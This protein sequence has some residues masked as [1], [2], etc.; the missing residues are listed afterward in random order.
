MTT[1]EDDYGEPDTKQHAPPVIG[2][3][4]AGPLYRRPAPYNHHS[5]GGHPRARLN[6][7]KVQF[8]NGTLTSLGRRIVEACPLP[9]STGIDEQELIKKLNG[10]NAYA[11][12]QRN[13]GEL[14]EASYL[15]Q[16]PSTGNY[17]R[18]N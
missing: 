2:Y 17:N 14:V 9:G 6:E 1:F 12:F 7:I 10:L 15:T 16:D 8:K 18:V 5:E 4:N 13:I 3:S 11:D